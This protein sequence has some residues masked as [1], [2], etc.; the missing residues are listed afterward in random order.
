[1]GTDE[2]SSDRALIF[3]PKQPLGPS[4][5]PEASSQPPHP[6]N[7]SR[8]QRHA[9][10]ISP[11]HI[12]AEE[13]E[14]YKPA[15]ETSLKANV[16]MEVD[17]VIGKYREGNMLY[18][19]A[20]Y[21]G[22]IAHKYLSVPF[23]KKYEHL[24]DEFS[25]KRAAGES[26]PFDPSAHYVHPLSRVKM[27]V[28]IS[29]QRATV[30]IS[31]ARSIKSTPEFE[32]IPDSQDEGELEHDGEDD[33]DEERESEEDD[34]Y[35]EQERSLPTRS[36]GRSIAKPKK[37][38]PFSPK[39][40]RATRVFVIDS[41]EENGDSEKSVT[42]LPSR[43]STRIQ[44][45]VKVNLDIDAFTDNF[46][47]SDGD[48]DTYGSRRSQ[49]KGKKSKHKVRPKVSRAAYGHFRPIA[50]LE[51]ESCSDEESAPFRRHRDIC[52]KCHKAPA[53]KLIQA[54]SK[55]GRSKKRKT[56]ED[57]FDVSD[58]E[59]R[60]AALGGWVRCLK[61]PVVAHWRCMASTQRDEILKAARERDRAEWQ[62]AHSETVSQESDVSGPPE[63]GKRP[64]LDA[65][66][67]TEF[68]CNACIKGGFCMGCM[69]VALE[70]DAVSKL[71]RDKIPT[72]VQNEDL[73][74]VDGIEEALTTPSKPAEEEQKQL[75]FR[76]FTCKRIAHYHHLPLPP[77]YSSDDSVAKIA[78]YYARTWLCA[79][80]ASYRFGVDKIIA[81]RPYPSNAAEPPHHSD[82]LPNYKDSL[83]REYLIKWLD[84][85]YRRVQWV[86]HMWLLSTHHAKLKNFLAGGSKVELLN[87]PDD[88]LVGGEESAPA[89][90]IG[91]ESRAS[92]MKP[93]G[94]TPALP[95]DAIPDA[96]RRIPP[97]WKSIDRLLD[98]LLWRPRRQRDYVNKDKSKGK[99]KATRVESEPVSEQGSED[100]PD[101]EERELA[102][103][104]GEQP[105]DD[106]METVSQ[107]EARTGRKFSLDSI[108]DVV[109]AFIKWNDLGYDEATWD[110]PPRPDDPTYPAF[111][112]ALTRFINSRR[113][114]V[115]KHST[116]Y[117]EKFDKRA[118][119]EYRTRH[120]LKD[121]E[122]L[123]IGQ[124][125]QLKL[126]PFQVDGF[127]WLCNN[128]WTHQ[129][130]ILADE[131]GLGKTV[132]VATF[133]GNI[134]AKF[135][136]F[137]ALV[138][139]P[140]S[141]ITNWVRE[142]ER[143]APKLRVVPFY[144]EAKA[145]DVIKKFELYHEA[146]R[147]GE[148]GAKFHVLIT[149]YEALLNQK[150]FTP[151]F[152]NQPRWEV[153]VIDEGQR[154]KSDSSLLFRRLNEINSIHRVIMT[155]TPLNNNIR[156]LFNL[157]NFLDP[158]EW[159]DLEGL[160]KEHEELTEDL[161]KQLHN[162]LRPYFL[163]RLK[164]EVLQLPPKNEVIVPVSMAPLQ[165]EVYR[166]ILSHNLELLTG[167]TQQSSKPSSGPSKGRINNVL[168]ELRK[169]LQHPYLNAEDIEPRGLSPQET[170]E[171]LIDG[172]AKLRLLKSL[173]PRLK[174]RGHRVLLF[175]QF[176][177]ALNVIEDFLVGEGHKYLR[178]DGNTKGSE[179]QKGMDEFN[180][181]GS[182]MFIYLL[183]TR[184]GGVGINLFSADTV[185]IFDPDFNP[186]QDLQ[187]IARAY[188]YGQQKTCLVFK[189]MVKDSAEGQSDA[190]SP[191]DINLH[192][193]ERI[194][195]VGKKKLVLD[196]LIVQKMDEED[197]AGED[198][199]SILTYGAQTLF[200]AEQ[201]SRDI[202]YTD[203]DVEKLI[204]KTEKEGE[205][206]EEVK[207]GMSFAFAKVWAAD[208]D[209]LE[210]VEDIDQGDSWAQT[211]QKITLERDKTRSE[212][213]ALSG[214]G[215]KRRAAAIPK[216]NAYREEPL[217]ANLK[218]LPSTATSVVSDGSGY[219]ISDIESDEEGDVS[220]SETED[221]S[222]EPLQP[223]SKAK[224]AGPL[225]SR[226]L[227]GPLSAI[228]NS[229][230]HNIQYCGLCGGRHGDGPGECVM[231]ERSENLAEFREML[232][233]H[234]D[235]EPWE[236]RTAAIEAIDRTLHQRGH[237]NLIAGQ[238][239]H[240]LRKSGSLVVQPND[241]VRPAPV[242]QPS[243]M[244]QPRVIPAHNISRKTTG[245][246]IAGPSS[247]AQADPSNVASK[248]HTKHR[249]TASFS[250]AIQQATNAV[251]GPSKRPASPTI[252][253][254]AKPKK[255]KTSVSS[256][257]CPVCE[258]S[259]H[260]LVKDCPI[261]AEGTRS[262][263]EQIIRLENNPDPTAA[264]TVRALR[265]LLSR[266][267][268]KEKADADVI[269]IEISD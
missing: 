69:E 18:Y 103:D 194:V 39:K 174:E 176:V 155:G 136:A 182:D 157:M 131:M 147:P 62:L 153:L 77:D 42:L 190:P 206:Q 113:V 87:A 90:E 135:N 166:S 1:M 70:P 253:E 23:L 218:K 266:Q 125:R 233:L 13:K 169:C 63:P 76:C 232:L 256:L 243:P 260:H 7:K 127:N 57:D 175:S 19:F 141:T 263:T 121:A 106:V 53:H 8:P 198:V 213:V 168:M 29:K 163:R 105:S 15:N 235:D 100:S 160:E 144:G 202:I 45:G 36:S 268:R 185:I 52:E 85:S 226:P 143:W 24:V 249:P 207:E 56:S 172:S 122:D 201:T 146:K 250:K 159:D 33:D 58:D 96:E 242:V 177:I 142:F 217:T 60:F 31:S 216:P 120:I 244:V 49:F 173:L 98:V 252:A 248:E 5:S 10:F 267:M 209:S 200:G 183:T 44:K 126:M 81:W 151:V 219:I 30:D 164:S 41:D 139:V 68:L 199:Q 50:E 181:P 171:K 148:T 230:S 84:R 197:S 195:Q 129:H 187:A 48:S 2:P 46:E 241:V 93:G 40:T 140:N 80:C 154:L 119:D 258:R 64:G 9:F 205:E 109:W 161:V 137:P 149:T 117:C 259:P 102:F 257:P 89:F 11:P 132:Q 66:Q 47:P 210:E 124:N 104:Q 22:G 92:S 20:R 59:E 108:K 193:I 82:E 17:E 86:P 191:K 74:M 180:K 158:N 38:L 255:I 138:V 188:R 91:D 156:E 114:I 228:H 111:Q 61:C 79:D 189:L 101:Q 239:L 269:R 145:R 220:N 28:S 150:D 43:R 88:K 110:S 55:K 212:E 261:V 170:H 222:F 238:P 27:T 83:P 32:V 221:R 225:T 184:A 229:R 133:L 204:E 78:E 236:R 162:R 51:Y 196:H 240:P 227:N 95:R 254:Q 246:P 152:K 247:A 251:A 99:K 223:K 65:S 34:E 115:P 134:A 71:Q 265:K 73:T 67:T 211:L 262:I 26:A 130:C 14:L 112:V 75:V 245:G 35:E 21:Q 237:I 214:R 167:L 178:L 97:A 3:T 224:S 12:P 192:A 186:H 179:R 203:N 4:S 6:V 54:L 231:T 37:A 234:A 25:R 116:S 165:K 107:W 72:E 264:A 123:D 215:V 118:K 94:I 128:W 16:E 208:K